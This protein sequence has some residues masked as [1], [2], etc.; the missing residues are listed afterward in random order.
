MPVAIGSSSLICRFSLAMAAGCSSF[1]G[2]NPHLLQNSD[3]QRGKSGNQRVIFFFRDQSKSWVVELTCSLRWKNSLT[4]GSNTF[5]SLISTLSEALDC[6]A[7]GLSDRLLQPSFLSW[8]KS[9]GHAPSLAAGGVPE[10]RLRARSP[11]RPQGEKNE[12]GA[13]NTAKSQIIRIPSGI[14]PAGCLHSNPFLSLTG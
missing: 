5:S 1:P 7:R 9:K 14:Y 3:Y 8:G 10:T 12:M 2:Q 4:D 11:S 6:L 13:T